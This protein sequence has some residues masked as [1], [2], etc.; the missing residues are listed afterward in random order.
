MISELS[1]RILPDAEAILSTDILQNYFEKIPSG[2]ALCKMLYQDGKPLDFLYLYTNPAFH[3]QTGLG[4]VAAKCASEAI[5]GIRESTPELFKLYGDVAAGAPAGS[6]EI[7]VDTLQQWFSVQVCSPKP[8]YFIATFNVIN[9]RKSSEQSLVASEKLYR[10]LLEDQTEMICRFKADGTI[11]YVNA[12]YCRFFG[13]NQES[14]LGTHWEPVAHPDDVPYI[15]EQLARLTIENPIIT[16]ENRVYAANNE[17]HWGQ[18]VNRAFFDDNGGLVEIQAVGRDITDRKRAEEKANRLLRLL[19]QIA[20]RVP[21]VVYQYRLRPDGSSCFPFASEAIR[22]IYR[23][24]PE[25]VREDAS[26]V[27]AI[28][29]PDDI[30]GVVKSINES[31]TTLNLWCYEYRVKFSD[32]AIRWLQG[33][34][35]P[36]RDAD[37]STLWH[38]FITDVTQR[39]E[40]EL[41]LQNESEKNQEVVPLA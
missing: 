1:S 19:T 8:E 32:G 30:D 25:Q 35:M 16:I 36:N 38:G 28:L 33:N 12:A 37:G 21:G 4:L 31:A 34:A 26:A 9:Q 15:L 7:F 20:N 13:L 24:S 6:F 11:L 17:L 3:H 14:V 40:L 27:F 5:P 18:F 23:V 22:S 29:H 10:G 41:V 2:V 39:K